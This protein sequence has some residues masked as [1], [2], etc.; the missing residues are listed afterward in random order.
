MLTRSV[1]Y[2]RG[3]QAGGVALT[4]S[5]VASSACYVGNAENFFIEVDYTMGASET[6][7]T[8]QVYIEVADPDAI[9]RIGQD[10]FIPATTDWRAIV[11]ETTSGGT[12]TIVPREYTFAA[13]SAAATYDR[14]SIDLDAHKEGRHTWVRV[15]IKETGV[16]TNAGTALIRV[17][18]LEEE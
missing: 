13:V 15:S 12:V 3:T 16:A 4:S 9:T 1:K 7:N 6:S 11:S 2:V 17:V 18:T 5:Y 10:G 14:F 8:I